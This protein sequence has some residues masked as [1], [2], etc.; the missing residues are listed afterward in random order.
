MQCINIC[1]YIYIKKNDELKNKQ[2]TK[3][4]HLDWQFRENEHSRSSI[5]FFLLFRT[6][7]YKRT[8]LYKTKIIIIINTVEIIIKK[9]EYI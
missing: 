4:T 3:Q 6:K 5:F 2:K 1:K 9:K 8:N 7:K